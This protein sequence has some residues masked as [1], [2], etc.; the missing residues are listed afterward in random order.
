MGTLWG[1][2]N[3][4]GEL[5]PAAIRTAHAHQASVVDI[6]GRLRCDACAREWTVPIGPYGKLPPN[7]WA[8][9]NGCNG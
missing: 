7:W 8:C 1:D 5:G 9:P 4:R 3:S 2:G 6:A